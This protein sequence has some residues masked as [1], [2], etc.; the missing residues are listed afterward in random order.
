MTVFRPTLEVMDALPGAG[1][2][3]YFILQARELL[4]TPN[5]KFNLLYVAPTKA[6]LEEVMES[7]TKTMLP[8]ARNKRIHTVWYRDDLGSDVSRI[9]GKGSI[10]EVGGNTVSDQL[11]ELIYGAKAISLGSVILTTYSAF[12]RVRPVSSGDPVRKIWVFFDEARKCLGLRQL[13]PIRPNSLLPLFKLYSP[14]IYSKEYPKGWVAF[15]FTQKANPKEAKEIAYTSGPE[16]GLHSVINYLQT[17]DYVRTSQYILVDTTNMNLI[18]TKEEDGLYRVSVSK[19]K[20]ITA[21]LKTRNIPIFPFMKPNHMFDGYGR[22][23]I[24]SAY[25]RQSQMYHMLRQDNYKMIN[26]VNPSARDMDTI[27]TKKSWRD[28]YKNSGKLLKQRSDL[29]RDS[30]ESRLR[31]VPILSAEDPDNIEVSLANRKLTKRLLTYGL[32]VPRKI[33][34]QAR[35][36]VKESGI[37]YL[38][39]DALIHLWNF[40][41][42]FDNPNRERPSKEE[43]RKLCKTNP[44]FVLTKNLYVLLKPYMLNEDGE[45][46]SPL[47]V[48]IKEAV[49]RLDKVAPFTMNNGLP[50]TVLNSRTKPIPYM[51]YVR[52]GKTMSVWR[53]PLIDDTL[54]IERDKWDQRV[55]DIADGPYLNG[56]NRWMEGRIFIHFAAL[57]PST[58]ILRLYAKALPEYNPEHDHLLENLMQTVYRTNLRSWDGTKPVYMAVSH[59]EVA[60]ALSKMMKL[61]LEILK[62]PKDLVEFRLSTSNRRVAI[63]DTARLNTCKV[64]RSRYMKYIK[65]GKR[66][67]LEKVQALETEMRDMGWSPR[68]CK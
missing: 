36:M 67:Y 21:N 23:T 64:L 9:F 57:N 15:K 58:D 28:T 7:L 34:K 40:Y 46:R 49:T 27:R 16:S 66:E 48:L 25:F 17:V 30:I 61:K 13:M 29:L 59:E 2:T 26:M 54:Q 6:L 47:S 14:K 20:S 31:I 8:H 37:N 10:S 63:K 56:L 18:Y 1:K 62:S 11:G 50:L 12:L 53:K 38:S 43:Y 42:V 33:L 19:S 35:A 24:L 52:S 5:P 4:E 60:L 39:K 51:P 3:R 55:L 65:D 45:P 68:N 44:T 32:I 41:C 22:V